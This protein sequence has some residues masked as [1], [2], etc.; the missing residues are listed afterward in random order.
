MDNEHPFAKF[1]Y[2][3]FLALKS[4]INRIGAEQLNFRRFMV[5][6]YHGR[7]YIEKT[8]IKINSDFSIECRDE[9]YA[10][11]PEE[12]TAIAVELKQENFPT[13]TPVPFTRLDLLTKSGRVTGDLYVFPDVER[14]LIRMCQERREGPQGKYYIPWS[15]YA[16]PGDEKGIWMDMEADGK[17]AFWKPEQNRQKSIIMVHE[18]AKTA[19]F[20]DGL[21]NDPTR[22]AE[23]K[24]YEKIAKSWVDHLADCEHWG[25]IGGALAMHRCDFDELHDTKIEGHLEYSCDNDAAGVEASKTFSRY[26]A[27]KEVRVIKYNNSFR[28]GWDLADPIP[29]EMLDK[30]GRVK[31]RLEDMMRPA[32]WATQASEKKKG[33]GRPGHNLTM[34]FKEEW[35]HC[36]DVKMFFHATMPGQSYEEQAFNCFVRPYSDVEDTA[37]LLRASEQGKVNFPSYDPSRPYGPFNKDEGK[38]LYFNEYATPRFEDYSRAE[39]KRLDHG[40][41][42]EFF[43]RLIPSEKMD[44]HELIKWVA[45][46][47]VCPHIKMDY[48]SLVVSLENGVGKSTLGNLMTGIVGEHNTSQPNEKALTDERNSWAARKRLAIIPEIYQGNSKVVYN[49]LK[50]LITERKIYYNEKFQVAYEIPNWAH[51]Y[52]NSNSL[53]PLQFDNSDRRWLIPKCTEEKAP[54]KFWNDFNYYMVEDEGYRRARQ[55]FKDFI[56]NNGSVLP[57]EEAPFTSAKRDMIMESFT[58]G[59]ELVQEALE[60]IANPDQ[61][62]LNG[63][64]VEMV[65]VREAVRKGIPIIAFDKDGVRGMENSVE[66]RTIERRLY[67]A[68]AVCKVA[69]MLNFYVGAERNDTSRFTRKGR[70]LSLDKELAM[71]KI[72]DL[73]GKVDRDEVVCARLGMLIEEKQKL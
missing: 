59:Q 60:W 34:K 17:L 72:V 51:I 56:E 54:R 27:G 40:L 15:C 21:L 68:S 73:I 28:A 52:A 36:T 1:H 35:Y 14:K 46:L 32:T 7:Y 23:R 63:T 47:C 64:Q 11:T 31:L 65:R 62:E 25:A 49:L 9:R 43:D 67:K 26:M 55:F 4:Y 57:G 2:T 10:P 42:K 20:W 5:K 8:I 71:T 39:A 18:G 58:P 66:D 30:N 12:A 16:A 48:A 44:R 69:R 19:A 3:N 22:R 61:R 38:N 29:P 53:A 24:D 13:Y 70:V 37:R 45:T 6:E 33:P 41:L 50:S